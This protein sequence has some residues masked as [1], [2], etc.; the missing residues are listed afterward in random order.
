MISNSTHILDTQEQSQFLIKLTECFQCLILAQA[1]NSRCLW[2][3]RCLCLNDQESF[4]VSRREREKKKGVSFNFPNLKTALDLLSSGATRRRARVGGE[5][6]VGGVC[7]PSLLHLWAAKQKG[8]STGAPSVMENTAQCGCCL[9][10][11]MGARNCP[12]DGRQMQ[13]ITRLPA[14]ALLELDLPSLLDS[15][16]VTRL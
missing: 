3:S 1:R 11:Q 7:L 15:H 2:G 12:C 16:G 8:W 9:S 14:S 13:I 5:L 6:P 4:K 10:L